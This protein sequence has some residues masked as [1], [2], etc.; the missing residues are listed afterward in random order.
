M[1]ILL[2]K[3]RFRLARERVV[4]AQTPTATASENLDEEQKRMRLAADYARD[5]N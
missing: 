5:A 1:M 4:A 2:S 3:K